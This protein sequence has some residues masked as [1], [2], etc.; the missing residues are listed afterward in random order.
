MSN[1]KI[2]K[3]KYQFQPFE[4]CTTK[5]K[6]LRLAADMLASSA[7]SGLSPYAQALYL[8]MKQKFNG[9]NASD[10]SLTYGEAGNQMH[11]RTFIKARGELISRGFIEVIENN[12]YTRKANIYGFCGDWKTW[13]PVK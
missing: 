5:G 13:K 1:K 11:V 3:L 4:S 8:K 12:R 10:I 2:K 9:S 6:Y 7:W